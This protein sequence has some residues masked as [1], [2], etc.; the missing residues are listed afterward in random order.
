MNIE[1]VSQDGEIKTNYYDYLK[2][3][4]KKAW[5]IYPINWL[6]SLLPKEE[7]EGGSKNGYDPYN[8]SEKEDALFNKVRDNI[9]LNIDKKTGV[10]SIEVKAQDPLISKTLVDSIKE[11]LQLFIIDYR[12]NKARTDYMYYKKLTEDAKHDYEKARQ[13]YGS[14]SDANTKIALRSIE[15]KMEDMENDMQLKFNAYTT[16]NGQLQA[17]KAK[18]QERTPAFTVLKG[19]TVPI[20]PAGPKRMIFVAAMLF[21]AVIGTSMYIIREELSSPFKAHD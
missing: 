1:L 16:L 19:A 11:R 20:K 3:Y 8:I 15:L 4:Q 10:I 5:W 21:L 12:T 2:N 13:Q 14:L 7:D 17:A 6:K 9:E 18:V